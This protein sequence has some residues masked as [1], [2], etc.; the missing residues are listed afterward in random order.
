MRADFKDATYVCHRVYHTERALR[1]RY[2]D[3]EPPPD[4]EDTSPRDRR[5][6]QARSW[7]VDELWLHRDV[8][9][10]AGIKV[11]G[12]RRT[13]IRVIIIEDVVYRAW[14]S[15]YW[16]ADYPF[17]FM[18]CFTRLA[19][20]GAAMEFWGFG[21]ASIMWEQQKVYD[22]FYANFLLILRN[23]A[24][25]RF[26]SKEGTLDM[27]QIPAIHGLNI[28]IN[29]DSNLD[30]IKEL[31]ADQLP[32]VVLQVLQLLSAKMGEFIPSGT[33]VWTGESPSGGSS[34][35]AIA[36]LQYAAFSL[37]A[38]QVRALN[39]FLV[40]RARARVNRIQQFAHRPVSAELMRTS[41]DMRDPF[42]E[43]ARH[44]GF[45]V[46]MPDTASLPNTPAGKLEVLAALA[47]QLGIQ[48]KPE[49]LLEILGLDRS[50]GIRA[51]DLVQMIP[52]ELQA[53]LGGGQPINQDIATGAESVTRPEQEPLV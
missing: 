42:P 4:S 53:M 8:A 36:H 21:Y 30:D 51:D 37:I 35:R 15:P 46:T 19:L 23:Q 3:W 40:R 41:L 6:Q 50:Y 47:A 43:E 26:L 17:Q 11:E 48:L 28:E 39:A 45:A 34:G 7:R 13:L 20:N 31:P 18:R 5:K 22:E 38:P 44:I 12:T 14:G 1:L 10:W 49:R 33:P 2:P 29:A 9:E 16:E 52:P 32:P 24:V 25:G 27:S